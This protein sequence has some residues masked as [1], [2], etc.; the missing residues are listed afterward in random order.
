MRSTEPRASP[1][2]PPASGMRW[3]SLT[4]LDVAVRHRAAF[5]AAVPLAAGRLLLPAH[6]VLRPGNSIQVKDARVGRGAGAQLQG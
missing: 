3:A 1:A 2:R 4:L 6:R 5:T